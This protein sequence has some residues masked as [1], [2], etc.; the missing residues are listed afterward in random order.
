HFIY[1]HCRP[2]FVE[3][4]ASM[5]T[6]ANEGFSAVNLYTPFL[7]GSKADTVK[8]G[9]HMGV[10]FTET[11]SCYEGGDVHCGRCGTRVERKHA[12]RDAGVSD[13]TTYADNIFGYDLAG[14]PQPATTELS[15]S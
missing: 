9:A 6:L 4:F 5:E 15:S 11:W 2:A 7:H 12:F 8:M 3:A 13:P 10:P 1:T 14:P